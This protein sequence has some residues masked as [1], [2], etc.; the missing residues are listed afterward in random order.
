MNYH[1]H[2]NFGYEH[3]VENEPNEVSALTHEIEQH[4]ELI[5]KGHILFI[6]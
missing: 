5:Q 2:D 6:D 3:D 1:I 4:P